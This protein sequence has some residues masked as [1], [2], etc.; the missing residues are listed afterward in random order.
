[1]T[2]FIRFVLFFLF[3]LLQVASLAAQ[4]QGGV[5]ILLSKARSLESRGR[6]D[7]AAQNWK[8]VLLVNPNQ[9]EALAGLARF[10]KQNGE[11]DDERSYLDRLR[12]INPKDPE[13]TAIEK[14]HILTPQERDRLDEAGRLAMAHKPD[15]AMKIYNEVFGGEP[16][17]GKW[18]EPYYETE[19]A[20]KGGREKAIAQLRRISERDKNNEVYRL[21]LARVLVYDPKTRTEGLQ[22]LASLRDPGAVEEARTQWRQALLWEKENPAVLTFVDAYLQR[23]PDQELQGIQKTLQEKQEHAA[24]EASKERGF[25]ALR[26]KDMGTA[27]AQFSDVLRRSPN[28]ANAVAGMAFVRLN[29]KRFDEAVSL[30]EKARTLAPKRADVREGYETAKFWSLMQQGSTALQRNQPEAAIIAYQQA[31]ALH[32]RDEQAMLGI[33]QAAVREKKLPDA[34]A[35]FQQVL[36]QSPNNTD[37]I[38]GLAFIR[39]DEKKFDDAVGLFDKA[40]K[41]A[42]NRADVEQGYR[43]AKFWSLMQQGA[44]AL[45]QNRPDAAVAD[46]QQALVLRPGALDALHGLA[47]AA[48]RKGDYRQTE[49]AYSQLTTAN[50]AEA[51]NWLTLMRVQMAAKNP[52]AA[53][54]TAQRIPAAT[55]TQIETR[56]DYLSEMALAFYST[57]QPAEGDRMLRQAMDTA[58]QSD[59]PDA[60]DRR[61]EVA[62]MLMDA[63][64]ADRAVEIYQQTTKLHPGN[65]IAWAGLVGAYARQRNLAQVKATVRSM[66][67]DV[68]ALAAKNGGFLASVAAVYA[69]DGE[70]TE[71]EDMLNQSVTLDKS[72]GRQP[73]VSTQLQLA[74]IWQREEN[75]AKARRGYREVI[76]RDQNSLDAWRGYITALFKEG[77]NR[78]TLAEVQRIPAAIRAQLEQDANFLTLLASVHSAAGQ[79]AQTVQLLERAR[80]RY[81]SEGRISPPEL[82]L[83]LGWAMLNSQRHDPRGFLQTA[84]A[85]TDLTDKQRLAFNE[86]WSLWS[87]RT[88]EEALRYKKPDQAIAVLTDAQR[89][90]PN[91]PRVYAELALVYMKEHNNQKALAV[92]ESWGM[93]GAEAGDYRAAAGTA[94]AAHKNELANLFLEQ[95]LQRYPNDPDLLQMKGK[96][97]ATHGNYK[98][99]QTYLKSALLAARNPQTSKRQES[100]APSI[101]QHA[102]VPPPGAGDTDSTSGLLNSS[103]QVPACRKTSSFKL[104]SD[105]HVRPVSLTTDDQESANQNPGNQNNTNQIN[106]SQNNA[107]QSQNTE[108]QNNPTNPQAD[109]QK[110]QQIQDEIDVVENRNTPFS[111][112]GNVATGR[113][114]DAGIDRLI[115]EDGI[116]GGYAS[117]SNKVRFGA[118]AHGIYLFSGTPNGQSRVPFGTLPGGATFGQ[119]ATG[120]LAGEVQLSTGTFG[121]DV[122]VTPQGFPVQNVIGGMRFRPLNG[123]ITFLAVRESV[124][125]SLLS[126]AGV[127]DPG[128]GVIWGGVVSDTGTVQ[129]DHK[130]ERNGGYANAS[131]SYLTGKNVPD[132]WN[133]SAAAGVYFKVVKGLSVGLNVNGMHYDKNLSFF[134][135]G[136]GGYF[137]PQR[138][139][140]ASIPIT[141]FSRHKR[142][143]YEIRAGLGAQYFTDDKSTFFPTRVNAILPAQGFYN[144]QVHTGPN[145]SFALRL[146]YKLAPHLYFDTFATANNARDYNTQTVGFSLKLL[147]HRLP[148]NTDLQVRSIPDWKGNQPFSIQ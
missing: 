45:D 36:N 147:V 136:Q 138:Y 34:E 112:L 16:P 44:T 95:G 46:Y 82:D 73:A 63:G 51:Q 81:Q 130:G 29:Q 88:A 96:Q 114:G 38:T 108:N 105:M 67:Q 139:G 115:I 64:K 86:I 59:T 20:S 62:A 32:P 148:T 135:L 70:C 18:A 77:D 129:F 50:P 75:Y 134:S 97:A 76:S 137:S 48:E 111:D 131:F 101:A 107:N 58:A 140:L 31:L 133:A 132:N 1:M 92:Y 143:E 11:A 103:T 123:P 30:F 41:L 4:T 71:A 14:L 17:Q 74:D 55:K 80:S 118:D 85:R 5:D 93:A 40:R 145:Y 79:H 65:A 60:L 99:A 113:A 109:P 120:G 104:A 141:W 57:N 144:S 98:E 110:Q 52:K 90:L 89:D 15:E 124:K 61:L 19:A 78:S 72:A 37:A 100:S 3:A 21:W 24:Q 43:N 125:D 122:G 27:E 126:Y 7:L 2:R 102:S 117:A 47:G 33:A 26:G 13:I 8:Q 84:R 56:S 106:T 12:K 142:F 28:D 128:T 9:T 42:P 53:L 127:R 69:A 87:V 6:M 116:V 121:V 68:Y 23:Y 119:Q 22:L 83:Q 66:P 39:L 49:L 10:A 35:Q 54:E 94:Q 25:Q 146:G 91:D